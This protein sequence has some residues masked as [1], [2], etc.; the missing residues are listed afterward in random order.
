MIRSSAGLNAIAHLA[1]EELAISDRIGEIVFGSNGA[2]DSNG[3]VVPNKKPGDPLASDETVTQFVARAETL[4]S[5][6]ARHGLERVRLLKIDTEGHERNVLRGAE[7]LLRDGRVDFVACELNLPG[8]AQ[9]GT[10]QHGLRAVM[11]GHGYHLFQL[12][13]DGALPRLVPPNTT[14]EQAYTCN[15]LFA[16]IERVGEAWASILNQ[17]AAVRIFKPPTS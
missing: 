9:N 7:G 4:D 14:I 6:A 2:H 17:P 16:R 13:A 15:V 10:D 1:V 8:L 11:L 3:G 12:D 5:L